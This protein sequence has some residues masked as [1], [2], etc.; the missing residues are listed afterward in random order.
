MRLLH[1]PERHRGIDQV[2]ILERRALAIVDAVI[3]LGT[4]LDID[5]EGRATLHDGDAGAVAVQVLRDVV[6]AGAGAEDIDVAAFPLRA[7]GEFARM[8]NRAFETIQGRNVGDVRRPAHAGG[9]HDV[10]GMQRPMNAV[11]HVHVEFG[12]PALLG[13]IPRSALE[14][15]AGPEVDLHGLDIGLE[16][17]R[18]LVLG[19]VLRPGL[20]EGQVRE[21]VGMLLIVQLQPVIALAPVVADPGHAIDDQRLD[22]ERLQPRRSRD[23]GMAATHDQHRG[24]AI[25]IA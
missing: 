11:G 20:R 24:I 23:A 9:H 12:G 1:D 2:T 19:N 3:E 13:D 22:T 8:D 15:R 21:V 16:P 4:R 5:D 25:G 18:D 6:R 7:A 14:A 10:P 17:V